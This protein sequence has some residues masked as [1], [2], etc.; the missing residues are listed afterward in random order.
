MV[1]AQDPLTRAASSLL[2]LSWAAPPPLKAC[3]VCFGQTDNPDIGRAYSWGLL[4]MMA[5][6]FAL[7]ATIVLA[8]CRLEAARK[9]P[10]C[11]P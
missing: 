10:R 3:A 5:F 6:T 2:A 1:S 7:L 4:L 8:V 11:A 9:A